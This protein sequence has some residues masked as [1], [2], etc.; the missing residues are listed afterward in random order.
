MLKRGEILDET[1][2][3]R[4]RERYIYIERERERERE[5]AL[6]RKSGSV[7]ISAQVR[8]QIPGQFAF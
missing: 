6:E 4:E 5:K 1:E 3:E 2:G 7:A 8:F